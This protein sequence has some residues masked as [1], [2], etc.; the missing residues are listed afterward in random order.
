VDFDNG[1]TGT[2]L[3]AR[4]GVVLRPTDHL[5][6]RADEAR[7]LLNVDLPGGRRSRLFTAK[8]DRLR[9]TYTLTAR[10]YVRA[11]AQYV[12][13]TRDTSLYVGDVEP[14]TATLSLSGLFAYKLNWQTV[15]FV[16]Y[17]DVRELTEDEERLAPSDRQLF[18]KLSYAFQR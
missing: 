5:E 1:R 16:G 10:A 4:L 14:R 11:I 7:R 8:V 15:L 18:L 6:L 12:S 3:D 17:G 13:T 2:G 9:A